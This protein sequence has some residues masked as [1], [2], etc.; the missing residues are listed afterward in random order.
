M[1]T[2]GSLREEGGPD[3]PFALFVGATF[4]IL[5]TPGV[6]VPQAVRPAEITRHEL[7]LVDGQ[8]LSLEAASVL[9][10]PSVEPIRADFTFMR[11]SHRAVTF[12]PVNGCSLSARL[13]GSLADLPADLADVRWGPDPLEIDLAQRPL[14]V[15]FCG[16]TSTGRYAKIEANL[17]MLSECPPSVSL[18]CLVQHGA[19]TR[20]PAPVTGLIA[21]WAEGK[22]RVSWGHPAGTR[23]RL[24]WESAGGAGG[25][26]EVEGRDHV[27]KDPPREQVCRITV[28]PLLAEGAGEPDTVAVFTGSAGVWRGQIAGKDPLAG[29]SVNIREGSL[30]EKDP[31]WVAYFWGMR[32]PPG[33]GLLRVGEGEKVFEELEEFPRSGY[34]SFYP[35]FDAGDVF[36]L[37][38]R[39]GRY[40]KAFIRPEVGDTRDSISIDYVFLAGGGRRVPPGPDHLTARYDEGRRQI[41]ARWDPVPDARMYDVSL[42]DEDG[43]PKGGARLGET[44]WS[45]GAVRLNTTCVV[46]VCA[47]DENG[48]PAGLSRVTVRTYPPSWII[49]SFVLDWHTR[50]GYDFSGGAAREDDGDFL[51]TNSAGG[52][53]SLSIEARSGIT[54]HEI[55]HLAGKSEESV[56]RALERLTYG[57]EIDTDDRQPSSERFAVKL[58]DGSFAV[59]R[60]G[61]EVEAPESGRVFEYILIPPFDF[62]ELIRRARSEDLKCPDGLV[63]E[64]D[65]L[66]KSLD[67]EE[68][69]KREAAS[70]ALKKLPRSALGMLAERYERGGL[71]AEVRSRLQRGLYHLYYHARD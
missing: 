50:K 41:V 40:A 63:A 11:S 55:P 48:E 18:L 20:F 57:G 3:A 26:V 15:A 34:A 8:S 2:R 13:G 52:M 19:T 35:R 31:D 42:A 44:T 64:V 7:T 29:Y 46:S 68:W 6:V 10:G 51:I 25:G 47:F 43:S 56:R 62:S 1:G 17:A 39:D 14:T 21:R 36:A 45:F 60:I 38:L 37:R 27:L 4:L 49:G 58:Q 70:D 59:V 67:D 54:N 23:F 9:T 66:L 71:S 65:G 28:R 33:G 53:S 16:R 12:L 24:D 61:R 5:S 22:A 69:N 32:V 30:D